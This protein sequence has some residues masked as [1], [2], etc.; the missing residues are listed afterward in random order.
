MSNQLASI[1]HLIR[2]EEERIVNIFRNL[3][4]DEKKNL[5]RNYLTKYIVFFDDNTK[6]EQE[7]ACILQEI[8][9]GVIIKLYNIKQ[10]IEKH[11]VEFE[12]HNDLLHNVR[13]QL[14]HSST[15]AHNVPQF[16][17]DVNEDQVNED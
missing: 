5:L 2:L 9:D 12:E 3:N 15:S 17:D 8:S 10:F 13:I 11:Y 14:I 6:N 1:N 4:K 16:E 7:M